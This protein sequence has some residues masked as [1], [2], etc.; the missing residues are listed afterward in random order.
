MGERELDHD[1][2]DRLLRTREA[3]EFLN[4]EP[5]T[6]RDW[7]GARIGPPYVKIPGGVR[8]RRRDLIAWSE[9]LRRGFEPLK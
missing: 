4:F 8:Y 1:D 7:R 9:K 2:P 3:A 5:R 6:L